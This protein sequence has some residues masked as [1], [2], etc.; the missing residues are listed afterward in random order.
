MA[1]PKTALLAAAL[2]VIPSAYAYWIFGGTPPIVTTR[3]DSIVSPGQVSTHVHAVGCF[4]LRTL[5]T[6]LI[7]FYV[8][9]LVVADSNQLMTLTI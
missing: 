3:L 2:A 1:F 9:L 5:D 6:S 4:Y 8:R 7:T